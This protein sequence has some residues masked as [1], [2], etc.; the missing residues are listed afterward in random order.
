QFLVGMLPA[1]AL[2]LDLVPLPLLLWGVL[3]GTALLAWGLAELTS[4]IFW[5]HNQA[6]PY[7]RQATD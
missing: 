4:R 7:T 5:H 3:L 2:A 6:V 1:S